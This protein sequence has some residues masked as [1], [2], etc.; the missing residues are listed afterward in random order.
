MEDAVM[1]IVAEVTAGIITVATTT[2]GITTDR[3][4]TIS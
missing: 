2:A 4:A 1:I 3:A